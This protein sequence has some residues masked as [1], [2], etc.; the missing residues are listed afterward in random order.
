MIWQTMRPNPEARCFERVA[1][2]E[3]DDISRRRQERGEAPIEPSDDAQWRAD[4]AGLF[5]IC[6]SGGGIRSAT[7]GLGVLQGLMEK[8]F[9]QRADFLSTV[10]GGGY[11]GSWLQGILHR[12]GDFDALNPKQDGD[13]S[14][15]FLRKYSNY[16]APRPG[17]STDSAVIPVI[18]LR[19]AGLNQAIIIA[20]T[21]AAMLLC[22]LPGF[23]LELETTN[24]ARLAYEAAFVLAAIAVTVV[25]VNL[26]D[27]VNSEFRR[28]AYR[29]WSFEAD[30]VGYGAII[31]LILAATALVTGILKIPLGWSWWLLLALFVLH[32]LLEWLGGFPHAYQENHAR[33]R[34]RRQ[35]TV[36]HII[37]MSAV[38][39]GLDCGLV[40]AVGLLVGRWAGFGIQ[41]SYE[42]AAWGPPLI[43]LSLFVG[44]GL[45]I[46]LMGKDYPDAAREWLAR[47]GAAIA[48]CAVGWAAALTGSVFAPY[49]IM[50]LWA[51]KGAAAVSAASAWM[52]SSL[53]G[54]LAGQSSATGKAG[55]KSGLNVNL[56]RIARWAPLVALPGFF[57]AIAYAVH[58]LLFAASQAYPNPALFRW[59]SFVDSMRPEY[60]CMLAYLSPWLPAAVFVAAVAIFVVLSLRVNI[61]EFS[62][63]HFYKNRLVRCY[64]GASAA[65]QRRPNRFTGFDPKDDIPLANLAGSGKH[66]GGPFP[67]LN[68]TLTVTQGSELATQERKAKSWIFTPL[69]CGFTP[70]GTAA[71][72]KARDWLSMDGYVPTKDLLGG[73]LNLGTAMAISGAALN[74]GQGYHTSTQVAFLMTLFDVRLGWWIGNPRSR[75]KFARPGPKVALWPLIRELFG[76]LDERS[77][78]LNLAD[79]GNFDNLGLYELVRRRCRFI[80]AVDAEEDQKFE[81]NA[82]GAAVRKCRDDFHVEIDINP[83]AIRPT[84]DF[85]GAHCAVG[86][87]RYPGWSRPGYL[88]YIKAS[89]TGD[90][91][92]DVELYRR[93]FPVFPQ[94]STA[95][96]FFTESQFESYRRLGLHCV[97]TVFDF[98]PDPH[99]VKMFRRLADRWELPPGAPDGQSKQADAYTRLLDQWRQTSGV[100]LFD[101]D[102]VEARPRPLNTPVQR[103]RYFLILDLLQLME[104]VFHD[105][106][107][108]KSQNREHRA[109][110]GWMRIFRYWLRQDAVE[111]VWRSQRENYTKSFRYFVDDLLRGAETD[112]EERT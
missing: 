90:E 103:S 75:E 10:S 88:L 100:E 3:L 101:A 25:A 34:W 76:S 4:H 59:D 8:S 40:C 24:F 26:R 28:H 62:M 44:V 104:G 72:K 41:G 69:Y 95:D 81:F 43:L 30:L 9:L 77:P 68:A 42:A 5:G 78:Y 79:G 92:A 29:D 60:W 49:W 23:L 80:I 37:W 18:W 7:F 70:E 58:A 56:D 36:W 6:L 48:V 85:S 86:T 111:K 13:P 51:W 67:I 22:H 73:K 39:S 102:I 19:N 50:L 99:L 105:C 55:E 2:E 14:L 83:C 96:Q 109:Y 15:R 35:R 61:N 57:I 108:S 87:I 66:R 46:G 112:P 110:S 27:V 82:L 107:L 65:G 17:L 74:P 106:Q 71:D 64:L 12:E 53:G 52:V 31:P 20:A 47:A 63:H 98:N 33:I 97:R 11:I 91:P 54:V 89:V 1:Q 94:E 45:Q 93:Q 32:V 38:S 16:L 21:V 84:G